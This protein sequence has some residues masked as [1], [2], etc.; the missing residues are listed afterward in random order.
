[1]M[2]YKD[3]LARKARL[4]KQGKEE[5]KPRTDID[6]DNSEPWMENPETID[7]LIWIA[8]QVNRLAEE[9]KRP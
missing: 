7:D 6:L 1:M 3:H 8:Q 5:R 4:A 2:E 9:W